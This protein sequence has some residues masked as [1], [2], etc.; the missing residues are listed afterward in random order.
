MAPVEDRRRRHGTTGMLTGM[1]APPIRA[2]RRLL[3]R[4]E[5]G[6]FRERESRRVFDSAVHVGILAGP[7]DSFVVR[8]QDLPALDAALRTD[9]LCALVQQAPPQWRT[10]WLIRSGTPELH[11]Q[12]LHWLAAAWAAFGIHARSLD[13]FYVVTRTGWR[14]VLTDETRVWKRLRL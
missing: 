5:V 12:D 4:E 2:D 14:D 8:A 11:D 9:V 10:A 7:R 1:P 13:G 6:R 3:L